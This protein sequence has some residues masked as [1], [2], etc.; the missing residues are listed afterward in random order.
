MRYSTCPLPKQAIQQQEMSDPP[1]T[2]LP[3]RGRAGAEG[4]GWLV[5]HVAGCKTF[6]VAGEER[7]NL[8]VVDN[9]QQKRPADWLPGKRLDPIAVSVFLRPAE[10]GQHQFK[11]RGVGCTA[12]LHACLSMLQSYARGKSWARI[13][14]RGHRPLSGGCGTWGTSSVGLAPSLSGD[15][16]TVTGV[17]CAP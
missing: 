6:Q 9:F 8:M 12:R 1:Q 17:D 4:G 15:S 3:V 14:K 16:T 5:W 10:T 11:F 7:H 2:G 13:P